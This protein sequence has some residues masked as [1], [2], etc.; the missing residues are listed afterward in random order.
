MLSQYIY[1][2]EYRILSGDAQSSFFPYQ[3]K[4]FYWITPWFLTDRYVEGICPHQWCLVNKTHTVT[5][6]TSAHIFETRHHPTPHRRI[7]LWKAGNWSSN[8]VFNS[9]AE[10]FDARLKKGL[11]ATPLTR[12]LTWGV[13]VPVDVGDSFGMKGKVL[14]KLL[15]ILYRACSKGFYIYIKQTFG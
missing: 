10:I 4:K 14:C 13:P 7:Q 9:N 2:T 6:R 1:A 3:K 8:A 11:L 5:T 15:H 12:D